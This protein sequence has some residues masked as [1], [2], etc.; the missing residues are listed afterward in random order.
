MRV[1]PDGSTLF[2]SGDERELRMW[3]VRTRQQVIRTGIPADDVLC[4]QFEVS[5]DGRKAVMTFDTLGHAVYLD[6][7][8]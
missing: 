4:R 3:D 5:P 6:L 7:V 8:N 1:S 2:T